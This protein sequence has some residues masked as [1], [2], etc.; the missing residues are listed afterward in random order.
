MQLQYQH[1]RD[2]GFEVMEGEWREEKAGQSTKGEKWV[3][4]KKEYDNYWER[5]STKY[6]EYPKTVT[7][8]GDINDL[9]QAVDKVLMVKD[10]YSTVRIIRSGITDFRNNRNYLNA[11]HWEEYMDGTLVKKI[12]NDNGYGKKVMEERGRKLNLD[13][14]NDIQIITDENGYFIKFK[15]ANSYEFKSLEELIEINQ[16]HLEWEHKTQTI[17]DISSK[18]IIQLKQGKDFID[19]SEWN[20][21]RVIDHNGDGINDPYPKREKVTN[22]GSNKD[23]TWTEKWEKKGLE[24]WCWKEGRNQSHKWNEQ[25]YSRYKKLNKKRDEQGNELDGDES[26][27]SQIEESNCQKWGKNDEEE[28][29]EKWGEVHKPGNKTKWCDKWQIELS[30]GLKKGENWG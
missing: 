27:G 4:K 7:Q 15:D 6:T 16:E 13:K 3:E 14:L 30:T 1:L 28:W 20:N 10:D 26:D 12:I 22:Q 19:C 18:K 25:W 2:D 17:D 29:N 21:Q 8:L 24:N 23:G 9:D 11:E 5:Q